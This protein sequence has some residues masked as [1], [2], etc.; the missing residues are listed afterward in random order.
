MYTM[1]FLYRVLYI[2]QLDALCCKII[3][4]LQ[5][6]IHVAEL[7]KVHYSIELIHEKGC[8]H[9]SN[10]AMTTLELVLNLSEVQFT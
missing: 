6:Y 8:G 2:P 3:T 7:C 1:S 4:Y 10:A 5:L 9:L